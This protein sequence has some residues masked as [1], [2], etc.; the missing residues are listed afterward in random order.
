MNRK[1]FLILL[2]IFPCFVF[3]Q[4]KKAI[5]HE[6]M[7]LMKR[8][9]APQISA[10]GK[11]I[12]FSVLNAAYD[13]KDQNTDLWLAKPDGSKPRKITSTKSGETQYNW[14]PDN[15]T[16]AFVAKREGDEVAQVYTINIEDGGEAQ[17]VTTLSTGAAAPQ[18]SPDGNMIL[19][20]SKVYPGAYTDSANK[21]IAEEKK[22]QK[23]KARVYTTF[24]IRNWDQ[25]IDE[26]QTHLFV[27]KADSAS[28]AKDL[29]SASA[30]IVGKEGFSFNGNACWSADGKQAIF[31]ATPE[32][33]AAAY[34]DV[35]SKIYSVP[36]DSGKITT[37]TNDDFDYGNVAVSSDG[38]YLYCQFSAANN[39]KVYNLAK[40]V[41]Y[42]WPS[43]QGRTVLAEKLDRP[44]NNYVLS[45]NTVVMSVETEGND[46]VYA[47]AA[48]EI[49]AKPL[50]NP[51]KGCYTNVAVS[52]N[53]TIVANYES[54][55]APVEVVKLNAAGHDYVSNFNAD[56]L[57]ALDIQPIE[58]FW[59][60]SSRGKKIKNI[61]VRPAGFDPSKKYPLLVLMH[62]GPAISFK[63]NWG[64]RW[65]YHLLAAPGYVLVLTDYTGST[66][67]GEKFSQDIQFDPFKGPANEINEAAA[68]AVKNYSFIDG[69]NQAAAGAS[70]GGHLANWMQATTTHYKCLI[71]HAGLVNS[72][73]QW[74]TSDGIYHREVMNGGTPW[75]GAKAWKDQNPVKNA[76]K[77]KTPILVTVGE[78][79]FRVPLNNSIENWHVLQRMK[80]PSKLIVFPEENHWIL[81]AENSRFF[82]QE[83]QNWLKKY[84]TK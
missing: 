63:D 2:L 72:E 49:E 17:K 59:F 71:S 12:V 83:V 38:K 62:G 84:L 75:S 77:F 52:D 46:K 53:N 21:K 23:Y 68:Y 36:V 28:P 78:Q 66:G 5:T 41:R 18:W 65:N 33:T 44:I 45:G 39:Y 76:D 22:K 82:Y 79:D 31:I 11:W 55:S 4:N 29:F 27:Q 69:S 47:I 81:K 7:W 50:F 19:F 16:I 32:A 48:N 35:V 37:L 64:Y 24:P 25:W 80:V 26:K 14:S 8:V 51:S 58:T 3:A 20:T 60:T 1:Y 70:Y 54:A 9:G 34:K 61:L 6:D 15:K 73:D 43:M 74:G 67:Y 30:D 57:A 13:E 40:L 10:N 56:K 42:N